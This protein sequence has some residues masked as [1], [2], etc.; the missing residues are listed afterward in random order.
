MRGMTVV[1]VLCW[2]VLRNCLPYLYAVALIGLGFVLGATACAQTRQEGWYVGV[3]FSAAVAPRLNTLGTDNDVPTNCDQHFPPVRVGG[4]ALPLP[5][6]HPGC[7]RSQDTWRSGV[8]IGT[9]SRIGF[10]VGYAFPQW[11]LE[12]GYAWRQHAGGSVVGENVGDKTVEFSYSAERFS[13]I[14]TGE[15]FASALREFPRP[16]IMTPYVG[17]G[18]G[19]INASM[20]YSTAW[21][22]NP[23][24]LVLID[25]GRHPAAAG[26]LTAEEET[27]SDSLWA[28]RL[29]AGAN[30]GLRR[31]GVYAGIEAQYVDVSGGLADGDTWDSLRSHPS[32]A[33]PGDVP[34]RYTIHTDD[35][36]YWSVGLR[37]R[38]FY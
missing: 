12:A 19:V 7:A 37:L 13:A 15:W 24:P 22:R 30:F 31:E 6:D 38:Y 18:L 14:D 29:V 11:R 28:Y 27:L 21:H 4:V 20:H 16:G 5:L 10:D 1:D 34:V 23:D 36:G 33:A 9:G 3:D 32:S 2:Y 17:V 25:H 26:T 8:D 35:L